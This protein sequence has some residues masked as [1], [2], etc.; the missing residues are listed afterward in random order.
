VDGYATGVRF[1]KG[2]GNTGTHVGHLWSSAGFKLAEVTFT[3]ETASGWQRAIFQTPVAITADTTYIVSYWDPNGRYAMDRPYFATSGVARGP[4]RALRDGEDGP[5]GVFKSGSSAFP[6]QT[7][8]SSNYWVDVI[9][10]TQTNQV[11]AS[12]ITQP[13]QPLF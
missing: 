9:F 8:Q 7:K 10:E 13:V 3:G 11:A 12:S 1:Y 2:S 6:T 5:N 4:L